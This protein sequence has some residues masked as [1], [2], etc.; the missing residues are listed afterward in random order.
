MCLRLKETRET[1]GCFPMLR[2][3]YINWISERPEIRV[4]P[5]RGEKRG[6]VFGAVGA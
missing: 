5:K 6:D 4:D 3:I 1:S 2:R